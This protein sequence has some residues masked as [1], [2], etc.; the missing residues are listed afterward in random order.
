MCGARVGSDEPEKPEECVESLHRVGAEFF[1]GMPDHAE[2]LFLHVAGFRE[3]F[4]RQ[5]DELFLRGFRQI[6]ALGDR[7]ALL[8]DF[9]RCDAGARMVFADAGE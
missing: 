4:V 3:K 9:P 5:A 8:S 7:Q 6:V 2:R 1:Q